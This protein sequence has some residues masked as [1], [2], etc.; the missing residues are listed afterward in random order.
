MKSF[1]KYILPLSILF[2]I[3]CEFMPDK[4]HHKPTIELDLEALA[5]ELTVDLGLNPEQESLVYSSIKR[6]RRFHPHPA[7]LWGLAVDLSTSLTEAQIEHL[8]TIPED[9]DF[10]DISYGL[11]AEDH[12]HSKKK[13]DYF[14]DIIRTLLNEDQL[15]IFNNYLSYRTEQAEIL[16]ESFDNGDIEF[17]D[18]ILEIKALHELFKTQLEILLT[19][20]QKEQLRSVMEESRPH[21]P[22]KGDDS[23]KLDLIKEA[24]EDALNLT[25]EQKIDLETIRTQFEI[26]MDEIKTAL[27]NNEITD[28]VFRVSVVELLNSIHESRSTVF[29][30]E[31]QLIIDIHRAIAIRAHH[32]YFN[33]NG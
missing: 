15:E 7:S 26:F 3:G 12:E 29:T 13:D 2:L 9:K 16:K 24:M 14:N 33:K 27:I 20:D 6:G 4:D 21:H 22:H 5:K 8:L 1:T 25:D 17:A 31:Q 10:H 23:E 18:L 19:D 11:K 28:E 32:H 30:E